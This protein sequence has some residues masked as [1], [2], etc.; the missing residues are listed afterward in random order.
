MPS[1]RGSAQ[2]RR[3]GE[4]VLRSSAP[5]SGTVIALLRHLWSEGCDFVPEPVDGGFAPDGRE[6]LRFTWDLVNVVWLNAQ[7]HDDDVAE[8]HGLPPRHE[9]ARGAGLVLD[10]YEL[11]AAERAGFVDCMIEFAVRSARDEA[12]VCGVTP[13][14]VSPGDDG[15][16]TLWAITWRARAAAWMLDHRAEPERI[17]ER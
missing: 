8:L 14:T 3:A 10:G 5:Q 2:V 7:L 13:T 9:R 12:I 16:P 4:L 6:Q 1:C 17:I 15:F 11:P